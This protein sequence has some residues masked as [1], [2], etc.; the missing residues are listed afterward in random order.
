MEKL[1]T[2]QK[3]AEILSCHPQSVY[4]NNELPIIKI[5]G[6]GKRYK[7]SDLNKYLEQ[8]T[9]KSLSLLTPL[10]HPNSFK[11]TDLDEFDILYL[12]KNKGGK[13]GSMKRQKCRWNYGFGS[14]YM[15]KTK[16]EKVRWY[17]DY[18]ASGK[19]IREVVKNA[20]SRAEA[21]LYLQEK[22]SDVFNRV[23]NPNKNKSMIFAELA[24]RYLNDYAKLMK[25]SY[26]SDM[27]IV[28]AHLEPFFGT[29][30]LKQVS[31]LHLE[32]YRAERLKT[33]IKKSTINREL[34][35]L[36]RIFSLGIDWGFAAN[37]PVNKI[38]FFSEKDNLQERILSKEEEDCL[39]EAS[40]DHLKPILTVAL[41][42]GMRVSE[43]LNLKWNQVDIAGMLIRV[44]RTKSGKVRYININSTLLETLKKLQAEN[45]RGEFLFTNPETGKPFKEVKT[46]FKAA[47]RRAKISNLRFHDLR[48]TFASRLV[49]KGVDLITVKELLGH[50]TVK[51]TERYTHPNHNQKKRAVDLLVQKEARKS[52]E[53][54]HICPTGNKKS[55]KID[56][57]NLFSVN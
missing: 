12:K 2:V 44:E 35:I 21:V 33:G 48:H 18:A 41:N 4:R 54:A 7:V 56:V 29:M 39:L 1:L 55:S 43:I 13:N 6:I 8:N 24:E 23:H 5:Q 9:I 38:K 15:R 50:S 26:K 53:M 49:E 34:A 57:T 32:K 46:A 10:N 52:D 16:H 28:R 40:A 19:R 11:L 36:S 51:M 30:K 42:T 3:V 31:C 25:K 27:Y 45:D 37:N 17:V 47:C 14:V 20:Q 22:V